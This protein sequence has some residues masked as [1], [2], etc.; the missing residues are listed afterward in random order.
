MN[1]SISIKSSLIGF[2]GAISLHGYQYIIKSNVPLV[3]ILWIIVIISMTT[4]GMVFLFMNTDNYVNSGIRTDFESIFSM[5]V[6][7]K[8]SCRNKN[9][10]KKFS[11]SMPE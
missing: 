2:C 10:T 7:S 3:K 4:I 1:A 6:T 9:K 8:F 5:E 11:V